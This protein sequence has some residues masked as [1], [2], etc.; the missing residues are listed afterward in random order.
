ML[1]QCS[2]LM[3]LRHWYLMLYGCCRSVHNVTTMLLQYSILMLGALTRTAKLQTSSNIGNVVMLGQ[4]QHNHFSMLGLHKVVTVTF[5]D[6]RWIIFSA[7]GSRLLFYWFDLYIDCFVNHWPNKLAHIFIKRTKWYWNVFKYEYAQS[8][9][10]IIETIQYNSS[11]FV[12]NPASLQFTNL[13]Y[14]YE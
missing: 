9:S 11:D 7:E 12:T 14:F 13:V 1:P 3:F 5:Y 4:H 8:K 10:I 2:I 6:L